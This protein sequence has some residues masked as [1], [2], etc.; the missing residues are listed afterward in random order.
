MQLLA[1]TWKL[2][3][4]NV[5][6]NETRG[7]AKKEYAKYKKTH[8]TASTGAVRVDRKAILAAAIAASK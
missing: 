3:K 4:G 1:A 2:T 7:L 5:S 6:Y 8:T